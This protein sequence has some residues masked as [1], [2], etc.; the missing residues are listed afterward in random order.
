[1]YTVIRRYKSDPSSVKEV[2]RRAKDEFLPMV[3]K[4][5]GFV[6]YYGV[7][8][9]GGVVVTITTFQDKAGADE[10]TSMARGWV[11]DRLASLLPDP[12]EVMAGETVF[13]AT[14]S[15][16]ASERAA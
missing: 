12:P 9:G 2:I 15:Q 7:N 11:R 1:M 3:Q 4:S 6:A 13:H 16:R 5:P 8:L 14:A 10:S